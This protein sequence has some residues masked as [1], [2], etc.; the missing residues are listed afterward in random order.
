MA[1]MVMATVTVN[2]R[3]S[4]AYIVMATVT[5]NDRYCLAY[6]VMATVTV[7]D[8]TRHPYGVAAAAAAV[9]GCIYGAVMAGDGGGHYGSGTSHSMLAAEADGRKR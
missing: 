6:I 5:V 2:D 8:G 3:Y 4:L 7:N 9:A 1:Y